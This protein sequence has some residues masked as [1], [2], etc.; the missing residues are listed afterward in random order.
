[1]IKFFVGLCVYVFSYFQSFSQNTSSINRF[2]AFKDEQFAFTN[3]KLVDGS[4]EKIKTNQTI[5]VVDGNFVEVGNKD[6]ID[7]PD[8]IKKIDLTGK[9]IIPGIVGVHNHLHLPGFPFIGKVAAKLYLASGVTTIQT[10]G[11]TSPEL[12][13]ELARNIAEGIE[14]G[15]DIISSGPYITGQ[16]GNPNMIIP[17]N[18]HHLKDT[19][20]HW[21]DRGITWFKVYRNVSP[22]DLRIIIDVAHKNNCRV[23]G[24]LC[25]VT[26]EEAAI[27]GIDGIEHGLNS[28]ADFRTNKGYGVCNG[29]R[30]YMDE[31]DISSP[32]V[33]RL[34]NLLIEKKVF[35]N[36]TLAIY[37]SSIPSR[38]YADKRSLKA[39]SPGL[40]Q[41]YQERRRYNATQMHDLTREK[42]LKRIMQFEYAFYTMGGLLGSGA[43]AGRHIMPGY[44]DQRN[45]ELL[46]EAGFSIPESIQIMTGN[47]AR[48]LNLDKIGFIEEGKRADFVIL[49]GDLEHDDTVI[50][51]VE[52]VFKGGIGYNSRKIIQDINGKVGVE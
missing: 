14:I 24:H 51:K 37:E 32:E 1:M 33:K 47:G 11:S 29:G 16:G 41:Q 25:S 3:V 40:V 35:M 46:R 20:Q 2:I 7:V 12:E 26:F 49:D 18:I 23:T 44:G 19:M 9:T 28:A 52:L 17:R 4:D 43:D 21:I 45:F 31:L 38:A 8:H 10:C 13:I 15:P 48:I 6:D 39:M 34:L 36:S 50:R 5:I 27:L 30:E 22:D 42:R